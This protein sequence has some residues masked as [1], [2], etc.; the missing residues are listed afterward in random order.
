MIEEKISAFWDWFRRVEAELRLAESAGVLH[1]SL[2]DKL[3]ELGFFDWEVGPLDGQHGSGAIHFLSISISEYDEYG[4]YFRSLLFENAPKLEQW[5]LLKSKPPK[6]WSR[7]IIWGRQRILVDAS[8]WKFSI[9]RYDDGKY[10]LILNSSIPGGIADSEKQPLVV[11]VL[12]AE[13]GETLL[14]QVVNAIDV[15]A[16]GKVDDE[17]FAI[18]LGE[19]MQALER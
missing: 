14:E 16:G 2:G 10:D 13:L 3:A 12:I 11:A 7:K 9:Y 8:D 5:E 1:T 4:L 15:E 19:I 6:A 17:R 18:S